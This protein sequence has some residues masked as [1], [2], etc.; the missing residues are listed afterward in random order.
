MVCRGRPSEKASFLAA[1]ANLDNNAPVEWNNT[2]MTRALKLMLYISGILPN[3][4]LSAH[5]DEAAY[6]KILN[7]KYLK[8]LSPRSDR[9]SSNDSRGGDS[10]K[11]DSSQ[12]SSQVWTD[13][14][15]IMSEQF[16]EIAFCRFFEEKYMDK[17]FPD[18]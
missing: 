7:P 3:K 18:N 17:V 12:P 16:F 11:S 1:L 4:F 8:A 9:S 10:V 2:R 14:Q 6:K 15:I 13:E 5:C